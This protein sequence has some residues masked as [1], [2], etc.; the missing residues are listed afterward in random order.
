M[1]EDPKTHYSKFPLEKVQGWLSFFTTAVDGLYPHPRGFDCGPCSSARC[2]RVPCMASETPDG[3]GLVNWKP[4]MNVRL[5]Q[6]L[7][8]GLGL[9]V[10]VW[11][12]ATA[13]T[14]DAVAYVPI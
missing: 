5:I 9:T 6:E 12:A 7:R 14:G 8:T 4:T 10:P 3:V 1:A 11:P 13:D 2:G